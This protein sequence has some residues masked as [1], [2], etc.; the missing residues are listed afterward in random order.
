[1]NIGLF[2]LIMRRARG[3]GGKYRNF[4]K[5]G[6]FRIRTFRKEGEGVRI[7]DSAGERVWGWNSVI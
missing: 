6:G 1:M 4:S 3:E 2:M 5:R 7:P